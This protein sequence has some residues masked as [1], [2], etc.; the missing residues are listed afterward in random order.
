MDQAVE[1]FEHGLDSILTDS[2]ETLKLVVSFDESDTGPSSVSSG[3]LC[4]VRT[5]SDGSKLQLIPSIKSHKLW[6]QV[7]ELPL[8]LP[9]AGKMSASKLI[10]YISSSVWIPGFFVPR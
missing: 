2:V 3:S 5:I 1:N 9:Q 7:R 8:P 6:C 10:C 4:S